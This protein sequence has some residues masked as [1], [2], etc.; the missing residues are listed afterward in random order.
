VRRNRWFRRLSTSLPAE[1]PTALTRQ[2]QN[3]K[4]IRTLRCNAP[5][6]VTQKTVNLFRI[7]IS[8][9]PALI[10][11][12][13][14]ETDLRTL[15]T[16]DIEPWSNPLDKVPAIALTVW[17]MAQ[18]LAADSELV[19]CIVEDGRVHLEPGWR[20]LKNFALWHPWAYSE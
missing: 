19:A 11:A 14:W 18:R 8:H 7:N 5:E 17:V 10:G 12:S 4:G 13:A 1:F 9:D 16:V 20:F 15:R 2:K 6:V 3:W